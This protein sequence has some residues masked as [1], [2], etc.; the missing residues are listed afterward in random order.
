MDH[1]LEHHS[2]VVNCAPRVNN[3]APRA[4]I[5]A[6]REQYSTGFSHDNHNM[7]IAQAT[8]RDKLPY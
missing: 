7:F 1:K 4:I 2:M 8:A 5:Y 6:P 3:Y